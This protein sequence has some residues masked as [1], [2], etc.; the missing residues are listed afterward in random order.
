MS[1]TV[2][3]LKRLH[4]TSPLFIGGCL[5]PFFASRSPCALHGA[6]TASTVERTTM[7]ASR[8]D[9]TRCVSAPS[10]LACRGCDGEDRSCALTFYW[11]T[12]T[13]YP[14]GLSDIMDYDTRSQIFDVCIAS[15]NA[16][17]AGTEH[18][19]QRWVP[20]RCPAHCVC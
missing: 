7:R 16:P 8:V 9:Q 19:V 20:C 5:V 17:L 11:S 1:G 12:T 10:D 14:F 2:R 3:G 6:P 4:H 13:A 15:A 18:G